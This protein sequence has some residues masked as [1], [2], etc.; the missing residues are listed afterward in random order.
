MNRISS[1]IEGLDRILGGGFPK[2]RA[3]L[4]AGEP[5]CGKTIFSIQYLLEGISKGEKGVFITIDEK[6]QHLIED[7]QSIGIDLETP[8]AK[9]QLQILDVTTYFNSVDIQENTQINTERIIEDILRFIQESGAER[10]AIDPIAPLIFADQKRPEINQYIRNL[11]FILEQQGCTSLLASY[12]PVGSNKVS[13]HG[14]E[15]FSASGIIVLGLEKKN[16]STVRT[17]WARKMRGCQNELSVYGFEIIE[18]RG[19]VIRQPV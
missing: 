3:Y 6:P 15:E 1:G 12:V 4:I 9:G 18:N 13:H 17:L 8:L 7:V 16:G 14:I 19:I 5:G 2:G 10:V 11:I